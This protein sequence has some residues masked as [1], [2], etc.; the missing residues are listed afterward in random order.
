[1]RERWA[2]LKR[3]YQDGELRLLARVLAFSIA[4][5]VLLRL[6]LPRM[7]R[8]IEKIAGPRRHR[9]LHPLDHGSLAACVEAAMT[10]GSPIVRR[11]CL[12][13][14]LTLYYFLRRAGVDVDLCFG[15]G[16]LAGDF[17]GHCWLLLN[18]EPFLEKKDPQREFTA[19]SSLRGVIG[20]PTRI[21]PASS[22][23]QFLKATG[24]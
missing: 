15:V 2:S 10:I 17:C 23:N 7:A 24:A 8:L 12:T 5:P 11:G 3:V 20:H 16:R 6:S 4:V 1:M 19:V 9:V 21:I 13:R 22:S 14:G 18:G